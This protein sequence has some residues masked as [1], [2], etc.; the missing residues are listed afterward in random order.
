MRHDDTRWPREHSRDGHPPLIDA[1]RKSP[2]AAPAGGSGMVALLL[3]AGCAGPLRIGAQWTDP[4]FRPSSLGRVMVLA[5]TDPGGP[6]GPL[7][8]AFVRSLALSRIAAIP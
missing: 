3:A 4:A 1:R 5:V 2:R 6:R 7:E 8:D